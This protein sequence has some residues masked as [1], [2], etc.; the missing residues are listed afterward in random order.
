MLS[1][2]P[3]VTED[4]RTSERLRKRSMLAEDFSTLDVSRYRLRLRARSP[5]LLP[6]Y[7]GSTLRGAFG[8]ALKEAVCVVRH[9]D[10][11][12]C[13]L[14]ER[15]I[16]PYRARGDSSRPSL[17]AAMAHEWGRY[18]NRQR[19]KMKM[20]GFIGGIEYAGDA[21]EEFLPLIVAGEILHVGTATTFG[22][23]RYEVAK[24]NVKHTQFAVRRA[25]N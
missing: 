2:M 3:Q 4:P 16:Y 18:S 12:R 21:I 22:L 8:H 11:E 25:A 24:A 20:G 10:C 19:V 1:S 23:G 9:R 6:R 13:M 15:C 5:V 14:A 17:K 7:P